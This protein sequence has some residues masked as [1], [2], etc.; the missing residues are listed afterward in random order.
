MAYTTIDPTVIEVGDPVTA[1]LLTQVKTNFDDHETRILAASISSSKIS[2][3]NADISIGSTATSLTTGCLYVEVLNA[4]VITEG[5]LQLFLKSPATTGSITIDVKKN[6]TTNPTGFN[7]V[8][9][10]M[11]TLN[12]AISSDYQKTTGTMN[13]TYQSL[14]AGD[15]LR[16]DII[17]IPAGLQKFK[18][19]LIGEV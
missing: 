16:L 19:V 8:F 4:C 9:I 2:L 1:D 15:I 18:V 13:P 10:T 6:T 11:P 17:S 12:I 7:S 14:I 5:S 3:I